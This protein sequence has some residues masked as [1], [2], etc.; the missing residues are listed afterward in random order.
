MA[1]NAASDMLMV[2]AF[3]ATQIHG[4]YGYTRDVG[5]TLVA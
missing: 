3:E 5:R 4:G 1:K 2:V